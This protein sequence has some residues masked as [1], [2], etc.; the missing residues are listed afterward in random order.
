[1]IRTK[2]QFMVLCVITAF[3]SALQAQ[4]PAPPT[5]VA[6]VNEATNVSVGPTFQWNTSEGAT[7]Y[8]LQLAKDALFD[9]VVVEDTNLV[10]TS[11]TLTDPLTNNRPYHWRM[12]AINSSGQSDWSSAWAFTTIGLPPSPPTL[13][14]PPNGAQDIGVDTTLSWNSAEGAESYRLEVSSDSTFATTQTNVAGIT[15]TTYRVTALV[16]QTV[17]YWRVQAANVVGEGGWSDKWHFTTIPPVPGPPTIV[18][19]PANAVD[20][21]PNPPTFTWN[22]GSGAASYDFQISLA[23]EF[24]DTA[25][26]VKATGIIGTSFTP[27][28]RLD[29]GRKVYWRLRS[30]NAG[31]SS[32]WV[33]SESGSAFT[34]R[35]ELP[36][37]PPLYSPENGATDQSRI[38]F[39]SWWAS[40]DNPAD[41]F[42]LQVAADSNFTHP[43]VDKNNLTG[44][45]TMVTL[46]NSTTYYWRVNGRNSVGTGPWSEVWHFTTRYVTPSAPA[47]LMPVAG[48][49]DVPLLPTF[50]WRIGTGATSYG[51]Q[52]ST[53]ST[54]SPL[55]VNEPGVVDTSYVVTSPLERGTPYYWRVRSVNPAGNSAWAPGSTGQMFT[56]IPPI[57]PPPIALEATNVTSTGFTAGWNAS[58]GAT[59]YYLDVATDSLFVTGF[60]QNNLSV[61]N[62]LKDTV[63]GLNPEARYHYRVRAVNSGGTSENSNRIGV[64]TLPNAPEGPT[65]KAATNITMNGF[66]ANWSGV[67]GASGYLLDVSQESSFGTYVGAYHDYALLDTVQAIGSLTAGTTY[68]YRV[69]AVNSGGTSGN[70]GVI[71]VSTIPAAPVANAAANVTANSFVATWTV[72]TGATGYYVDVATDSL[73]ASGFVQNNLSVGSELRD[74]VKSLVPNVTYY[75]RVRAGNSGGTSQNSNRVKVK[76]LAIIVS[77]KVLLEGPYNGSG[78]RLSLNSGGL[79]PLSQPY[80]GPP[81]NYPGTETVGAIPADVVDWVIVQL[82][83]DLTTTVATRAAFIKGDGTIVDVDGASPVTVPDMSAGNYYIVIRH[84]NHLAV[85]SSSAVPLSGSSELYDFTS[86]LDK[87]HGNDARILAAGIFGMYAADVNGNGSV[88]LADELTIIRA[89]NL[90]ERYDN[91]D[92]TMDGAVILADELTLLRKNN[93]RETKVP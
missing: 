19:P 3:G 82:R 25:L 89:N 75:Y 70:S 28:E 32:A 15:A 41:Y 33:P 63:K 6:P 42:R 34:M 53:S 5:L 9:T 83:S 16:R 50:V 68:Y 12:R 49:I 81:W 37:A 79:I 65:A 73:F 7:K 77:A 91:A 31:G 60:V 40:T 62:V 55:I 80:N 66:Q 36:Y 20:V 39:I 11:Y 18:F 51:F 26:D 35:L 44:T 61:G 57:P 27:S 29:G 92:V 38:L 21:T 45:A 85:M 56:T 64:T 47:V 72:C 93:L 67:P 14:S 30:V 23:T 90:R 88:V 22:P 8:R 2:K 71:M 1:M 17:Y 43:V 46:A 10:G 52:I 58:A 4:V 48:A 78:M 87:Y 54:F 69:R 74:T 76:T 59:S 86:G 24:V 84:R 13:A